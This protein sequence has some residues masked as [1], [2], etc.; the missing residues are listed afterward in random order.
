MIRRLRPA[1]VLRS[2][3]R[4][5]NGVGRLFLTKWPTTFDAKALAGCL[6]YRSLP[7]PTVLVALLYIYRLLTRAFISAGIIIAAT[8]GPVVVSLN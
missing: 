1:H 4:R 7:S 3:G 6:P 5:R 2:A 8:T